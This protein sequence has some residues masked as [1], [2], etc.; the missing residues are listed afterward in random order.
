M[1]RSKVSR[2]FRPINAPPVAIVYFAFRIMV[3]IALLMLAV[4]VAGFVLM[5]RG[6]A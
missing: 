6:P 1:A 5:A 2:T 3:G 4:V